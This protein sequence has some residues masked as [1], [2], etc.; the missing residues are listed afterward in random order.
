LYEYFG[1]AAG[2]EL[3]LHMTWHYLIFDPARQ[4]GVGEFTFRYR[5]QTHGLVIV[6]LAN[7]LIN[8]WRE[9]EV[10]SELP[11]DQFIGDNRF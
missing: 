11:W 3:P 1:G 9:Y 4:I 10:E 5:K 6:K 7:G 8:N 2:R